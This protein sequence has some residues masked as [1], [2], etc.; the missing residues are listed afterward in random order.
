MKNT[1][2]IQTK[3]PDIPGKIPA[4]SPAVCKTVSCSLRTGKERKHVIHET[5]PVKPVQRKLQIPEILF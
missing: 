5:F 2:M 4:Y 3:L 1:L